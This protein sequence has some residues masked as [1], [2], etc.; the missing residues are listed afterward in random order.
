[1]KRYAVRHRCNPD[2]YL[3]NNLGNYGGHASYSVV[4][5]EKCR[6]WLRKGD[7]TKA[8]KAMGSAQVVEVELNFLTRSGVTQVC[9]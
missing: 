1:M 8:A 9:E 5:I 3:G 4:G 7:A 6:L 2:E